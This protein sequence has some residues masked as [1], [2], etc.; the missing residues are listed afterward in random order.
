VIRRYLF[1]LFL[2]TALEVGE[3]L[4]EH[5]DFGL[6]PDLEGLELGA[7]DLELFRVVVALA[8]ELLVRE[9]L[10]LQLDVELGDLAAQVVHDGRLVGRVG[11][12]A[13]EAGRLDVA[14]VGDQVVAHAC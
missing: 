11:V 9:H 7:D 10:V 14:R 3:L 12:A 6:F 2:Q 8:V 13:E 5:L 1:F 4:L